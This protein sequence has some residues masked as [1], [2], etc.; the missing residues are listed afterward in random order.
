ML[1]PGGL[2]LY[3]TYRQ[4]HFVKPAIERE[5]KWTLE[6]EKLEDADGGGGFEY[7]GYVMRKFEKQG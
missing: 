6:V 2:F 7:F 5:A 1:K 3:I 4:P